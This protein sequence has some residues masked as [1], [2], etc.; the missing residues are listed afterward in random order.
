MT[1]PS[2]S[3]TAAAISWSGKLMVFDVRSSTALT[4][5]VD[6]KKTNAVLKDFLQLCWSPDGNFIATANR[7]DHV[8]TFDLR[9]GLR[10]GQ[11][12]TMQNE[13]NGMVWSKDGESLWVA[14]GGQPGRI[15][16]LP[17]PSLELGKSASLVAS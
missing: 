17:T 14:T 5:D 1:H 7:S 15:H 9:G 3:H 2:D 4:H 6:L 11:S 10:L 16:V 12:V 8:Y 13:V